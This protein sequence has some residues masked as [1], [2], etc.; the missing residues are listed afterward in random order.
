MDFLGL[1][2]ISVPVFYIW[3]LVSFI[4]FLGKGNKTDSVSRTVYLETAI[5]DLTKEI[6]ENPD[7]KLSDLL[8]KYKE[9]LKSLSAAMAQSTTT[10]GPVMSASHEEHYTQS[11]PP[12][13]PEALFQ[14]WYK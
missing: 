13:H 8:A 5:Q 3:G 6:A 10:A 12:H 14:N 4:R 11:A 7:K 1:L 2:L 9:E